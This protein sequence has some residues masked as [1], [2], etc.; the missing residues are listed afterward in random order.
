MTLPLTPQMIAGAYEFLRQTPPFRGWKLPHADEVEFGVTA[1]RDREADWGKNKDGAHVI[2]VSASGIGTTD[3]LMQAVAHEMIH[4]K[5]GFAHGAA[6]ARAAQRACTYHGW[7][8]KR[9]A[10]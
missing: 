8:R 10:L 4:A 6:F 2:R 3:S 9:F 7:D 5:H 1:H